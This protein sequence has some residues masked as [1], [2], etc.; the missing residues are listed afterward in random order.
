[1]WTVSVYDWRFTPKNNK[2]TL[3]EIIRSK[4]I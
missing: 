3:V 4:E 2:I 1:M